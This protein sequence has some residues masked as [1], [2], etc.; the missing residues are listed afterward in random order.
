MAGAGGHL[1]GPFHALGRAEQ[2]RAI[3]S[4]LQLPE[5]IGLPRQRD[6]VPIMVSVAGRHPRLNVLNL[7][8]VATARWLRAT[9]WLS[10]EGASGMLPGVL[11]DEELDWETL[12]PS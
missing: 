12:T 7:E 5:E 8:A 4:F 11:D 10:P 9:V 2:Q 1:S 3:A 6:V